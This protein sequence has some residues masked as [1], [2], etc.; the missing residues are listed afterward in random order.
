M[1]RRITIVKQMKIIHQ[2]GFS[3]DELAAYRP[4]VYKNVLDSA[5]AVVIYMREAGLECV[6][7]DDHMLSEKIFDYKLDS[8]LGFSPSNPYFSPEI[9]DAIHQLWKDPIVPK[10]MN[11]LSFHGQ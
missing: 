2:D 10:V 6:D 7:Y 3:N 9:V 8:T 1:F 5:Q 4:I 11:E